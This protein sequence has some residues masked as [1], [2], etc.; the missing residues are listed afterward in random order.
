MAL[1]RL[2]GVFFYRGAGTGGLGLAIEGPSE[3]KMSCKDNK[4]GSCTVEYVPF[5]PG[6][7]DVNITFGGQPIPGGQRGRGGLWEEDDGMLRSWGKGMW[8]FAESKKQGRRW[9]GN[10]AVHSQ[11]P[12]QQTL[13][14]QTE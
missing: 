9:I 2:T 1:E 4:D 5:T 13:V 10:P 8:R 12:L 3:A 11:R 14:T 6:D 7:Y